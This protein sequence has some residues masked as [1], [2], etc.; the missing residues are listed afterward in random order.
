MKK[1]TI[2]FLAIL[3]SNATKAHHWNEADHVD[4]HCKGDI[5]HVLPD[6]TRVDC[7][8]ETHAVEYDWGYKWAQ[9]LGQSLFYSAMTGKKAGIV[10][11]VKPKTRDRYVTR[12]NKAIETHNLN[13]DVWI[14]ERQ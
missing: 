2:T 1:L 10:L 13:I 3:I 14:I 12:L 4:W 11:I 6:R 7:L 8:T 9:S 5:E